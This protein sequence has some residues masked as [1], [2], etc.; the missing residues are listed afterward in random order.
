MNRRNRAN[1]PIHYDI[2]EIL[3]KTLP[4][5]GHR[6]SYQVRFKNTWEPIANL[7]N[8][9]DLVE[10]FETNLSIQQFDFDN[11]EIEWLVNDIVDTRFDQN[12]N[13]T[14]FSKI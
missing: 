12:N 8:C 14:M 1:R 11:D 9:R 6:P 13:V 5:G 3:S 10:R 7:G 4:G 2:I